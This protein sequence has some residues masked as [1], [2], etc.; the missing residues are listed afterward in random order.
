MASAYL[1]TSIYACST[2]VLVYIVCHEHVFPSPP[3]AINSYDAV[4][5]TSSGD[6]VLGQGAEYS[7]ALEGLGVGPRSRDLLPNKETKFQVRI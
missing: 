2:L 7:A 5:T 3:A 1:T 6:I 4:Q